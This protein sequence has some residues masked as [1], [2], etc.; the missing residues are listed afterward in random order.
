MEIRALSRTLFGAKAL[1]CAAIAT[2]TSLAWNTAGAD[3]PEFRGPT[4]QGIANVHS[5]PVEWSPT[6]NVAWKQAIPGAGWS[7]PILW[8]E[9]IDL[10][11]AVNEGGKLSLRALCLDAHTGKALWTTEVLSANAVRAHTKNSQAS[12]TPITD[13]VRLYVHFG[14]YGTAALDLNG[15][16]LWRNT[17]LKYS[18]VHGNGGS[19]ILSGPALIF[20]ADGASDPFIA[21]LDKASGALLWKTPRGTDSARTFSFSTPL[22]IKVNGRME[23][24]S[25]AS[26]AVIAYDPANGSEI[27][28]VGYGEGYSVVPRPV[29]G[30]GLVFVSSGFDHPSMLAIRPDGTGDVTAS[31]VAWKSSRG[32]PKTPSPLLVGTEL[33]FVSDEGMLTCAD[34]KTGRVHW[35]ERVGGNYSASPIFGAGNLYVQSEE[36]V[37]TVVKAG[38]SF[39][40]L[41]RNDL[42]E[43]T[44]ASWAVD[45]G[46]IYIRTERSLYR[47]QRPIPAAAAGQ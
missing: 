6:R 9:H 45:E 26:G 27:W 32:A 3:W 11:T 10:T 36:G 12:A 42:K 25:P 1:A 30:N 43:R 28:R 31:H 20:S 23:I 13:G 14:H 7:S 35:Q 44:L 40:L 21:A 5:L 34:A 39:T 38:L 4:G 19:P 46:I 24:V 16:V 8:Q 15:N 17:N 2:A 22:A 47:I 29:F 37:A 18:P 33:Y 41:N